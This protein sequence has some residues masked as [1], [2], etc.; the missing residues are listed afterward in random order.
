VKAWSVVELDNVVASLKP[1]VGARLQ[2]ILTLGSDIVLGFYSNQ[3]ILW[4]WVD[5]NAIRPSVLP[6]ADQLPVPLAGKKTPVNLFLRAHF[7]GRPLRS[8]ERDTGLGRV[9]RL[10]FDG[11]DQLE[12]RL[13]PH[14]AN[15]FAVAGDKQ[16]SWAKPAA[17]TGPVPT[18]LEGKVRGLEDLR[19]E[20]QAL[21]GSTKS[22]RKAAAQD[23]VAKLRN[24]VERKRK[25][26][27]KVEEELKRKQEL[28][29]REVGLWLKENQ[30]LAV[31]EA[32]NPFVDKRRKLAWNIDQ[33][34]N[35]ARELE[36]K[37]FGTEQRRKLLL[38]DIER[39]ERE[40]DKPASQIAL[41]PDKPT[42]QPLKDSQAEGRTLRINE[43]LV[44][45]AGRNASDNL[46]LLR[47]ARAWDFWLHL[48][49]RP[50]AHVILFR[51]KS[52]SVSDAVLRQVIEWFVKLQLGAKM[53][54]HAGEKIKF[55]VA[56][57]RH[58]RPIKGDKLGRV[59]YQDERVLI[60][61]VPH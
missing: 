44:A 47:K 45:V 40:M 24:E 8:V 31:P 4:L 22:G 52:T 21:R 60:F 5:L 7:R 35:K 32:W 37:L 39:L 18:A 23:P 38:A 57:C 20:W 48:Q 26:L 61:Q 12:L 3:Q 30:S 49:D 6:W 25:G 9:V 27:A 17:L 34:F 58:V 28:P 46:K 54:K 11:N 51:N 42:F 29:W 2:E 41:K 19:E 36:G 43:E 56:E 16:L 55:L 50:G 14:G 59:H 53:A 10:H 13:I 15:F 1:L 33:A